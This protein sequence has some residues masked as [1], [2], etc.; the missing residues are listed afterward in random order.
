MLPMNR[1]VLGQTAR[2]LSCFGS[3]ASRKR[4]VSSVAFDW[5]DPLSSSNLLT[6]EELAIQETAR[7]YCQER[8]LPRIL[9]RIVVLRSDVAILP[10]IDNVF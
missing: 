4:N 10:L 2:R 7:S 3:A 1:I 5:Q 9:G 6:E 8:L